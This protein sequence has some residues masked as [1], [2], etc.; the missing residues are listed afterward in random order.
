M[1]FIL[2]RDPLTHATDLRF[3]LCERCL[4]IEHLVFPEGDERRVLHAM[5]VDLLQLCVAVSFHIHQSI[6]RRP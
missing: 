4:G 2:G 6:L 3:C 5:Q 1:I